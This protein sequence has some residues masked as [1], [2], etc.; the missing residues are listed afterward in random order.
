MKDVFIKGL[1]T[2]LD[3]NLKALGEEVLGGVV[4]SWEKFETQFNK[5]FDNYFTTSIERYSKT[6]TVLSEERQDLLSIYQ[7]SY[8]EYKIECDGNIKEVLSSNVQNILN[9]SQYNWITGY[10]GIGKSTMLK[11]FFITSLSENI[12]DGKIPVYIELRKYNFDSRERRGLIKFIYEEMNVLNFDLDYKYFEYMVSKGRFLFLLDAF[13]EI[14]SSFMEQF[15]YELDECLTKYKDN[16][17]IVTSRN[18]PKGYMDT[19]DQL[20]RYTTQGLTMDQA[21]SL[22]NKISFYPKDLRFLFSEKLSDSLFKE[23]YTLAQNPILLMLM[24]RTF[25]KNQNFPKEKSSFLLRVFGVLYEEHDGTKLGGFKRSL[26]TGYTESEISDIFS[27]F[28]FMT[29]F[30]YKGEK[31][32]FNY[33]EIETILK[34]ILRAKSKSIPIAD[35]LYDFSVC[36]C[37]IYKEGEKYY[38]VHNIFQEFYAAVYLYD[39]DKDKQAE[40]FIN[41]VIKSNSSRSIKYN[42]RIFS[43]TFEYFK[44]LDKFN[45]KNYF[46]ENIVLPILREI[47]NNSRFDGYENSLFDQYGFDIFKKESGV[48]LLVPINGCS[49]QSRFLYYII[50]PEESENRQRDKIVLLSNEQF[51]NLREELYQVEEK[52]MKEKNQEK[53]R[54]KKNLEKHLKRKIIIGVPLDQIKNSDLMYD[55]LKKSYINDLIEELSG[56]KKS[57]ETKVNK[58]NKDTDM[59]LGF[60]N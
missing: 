26:K 51:E 34:E 44:E 59:L 45:S 39:L 9:I 49:L 1:E 30:K 58:S 47:E 36:L 13:D 42:W 43:T 53:L 52:K 2:L 15:I 10:G 50:R 38:F 16:S 41:Q 22:I 8:L 4:D 3:F 31:K 35:I 33:N 46:E 32:E 25:G 55:I 40:F 18:M 27:S 23:Y 5:S 56:L 14:S 11:Y 29:Y 12:S 17:F 20:V 24:L 28:C 21:V 48:S 6:P 19:I 37:L 57:L 60:I 54:D 7:E